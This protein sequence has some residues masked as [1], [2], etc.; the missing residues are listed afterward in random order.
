MRPGRVLAFAGAF[1]LLVL[2]WGRSFGG[3]PATAATVR[4]VL[5]V[6]CVP[7]LFLLV[8]HAPREVVQ[9]LRD[10]FARDHTDTPLER[11]VSGGQALD[12]LGRYSL[13]MGVLGTFWSLAA[14]LAAL[15]AS[16]TAPQVN[17]MA[18]MLSQAFLLPAIGATLRWFFYAPLAASLEEGRDALAGL[19]D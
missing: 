8:S 11:L 10:A 13:A 6:L 5:V 16:P 1:A 15:A 7:Y 19:Q 3:L 17:D 12:A 2:L 9:A 18:P 14:G 4:A